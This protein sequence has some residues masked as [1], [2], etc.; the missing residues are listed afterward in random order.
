VFELAFAAVIPLTCIFAFAFAFI[1]AVLPSVDGAAGGGVGV[2]EYVEP[3]EFTDCVDRAGRIEGEG[4]AT[5]LAGSCDSDRDLKDSAVAGSAPLLFVWLA[6]GPDVVRLVKKLERSVCF[7]EN[8]SQFLAQIRGHPMDGE[9]DGF[10]LE[11]EPPT[12]F[13]SVELVVIV[14]SVADGPS[15]SFRWTVTSRPSASL[16]VIVS[17]KSMYTGQ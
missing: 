14:A 13:G 16:T 17:N 12:T 2:T 3:L 6:P 4:D 15:L 5:S 11:V 8:S 1:F 10:E 7:A 9:T